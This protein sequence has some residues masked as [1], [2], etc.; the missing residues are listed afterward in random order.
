MNRKESFPQEEQ[1]H[2]GVDCAISRRRFL[3]AGTTAVA[4]LTVVL[5]IPGQAEGQQAAVVR[6]P[7]KKIGQLSRLK[8]DKPV[9]FSYPDNGKQSFSMLVKLG[10]P[11]GGGVGRGRDVVAFNSTC[12][13]QGGPLGSSYKAATKTLGA[14]PL[15]LSTF[16]LT[17]HGIIVSG[18]AYQSLPQVLL[19]VKGDN[20][21]AVGLMGLIFGR[22]D[23][24]KG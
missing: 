22:H 20:I 1:A 12:T 8:N 3:V 10:T 5:N 17:R 18:Q 9:S 24:L 21:Y 7:R 2:S 13:H 15:H 16:D 14:C 19:E 11:A 6:Y 4:T 23:N